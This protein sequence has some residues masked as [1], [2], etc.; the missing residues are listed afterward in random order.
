MK[1]SGKIKFVNKKH[2][3][4]DYPLRLLFQISFRWVAGILHRNISATAFV[5]KVILYGA[6]LNGKS[7]I[8]GHL[9]RKKEYFLTKKSIFFHKSST[10]A[11]DNVPVH[12]HTLWRKVA[13][14]C[15]VCAWYN[16]KRNI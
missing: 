2:K 7:R 1:V 14:C 5:M 6:K 13:L 12:S 15:K 4:L 11:F 8:I 16:R 10:F 3:F 9:F